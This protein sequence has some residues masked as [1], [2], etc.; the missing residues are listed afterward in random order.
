[1]LLCYLPAVDQPCEMGCSGL[2]YCTNFNNRPTELFRTCNSEADNGARDVF[3]MWQRGV[4]MIPNYMELVPVKGTHIYIYIYMC[5]FDGHQLHVIWN[6]YDTSLPHVK[7]VAGTVIGFAVTCSKQLR[8]SV[9]EVCA[10]G[11]PTTP[12]LTWLIHCRQIT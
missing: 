12:H 11:E 1:M 7:H 8:R 10:V 9:V 2:S 3:N 6:H 5:T 4:I